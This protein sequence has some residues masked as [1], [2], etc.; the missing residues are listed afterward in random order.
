MTFSPTHWYRIRNTKINLATHCLDVINDS[1]GNITLCT[2]LLKMATI[3][4]YAGQCWQFAPAPTSPVPNSSNDNATVGT[5]ILR[6]WWLGPN[7]RLTISSGH[8]KAPILLHGEGQV[9][10]I[11][12]WDEGT[13]W[14]SSIVDGKEK[15]LDVD[16]DG[17]N[18]IMKEKDEGRLTQRWAV[19][20]I[21]SITEEGY[22]SPR[23]DRS[24]TDPDVFVMS[25]AWTRS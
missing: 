7:R 5:Y 2:G 16:E 18:L 3:G 6:T 15:V 25:D 17:R 4:N 9:W 20:I 12:V 22:H 1:D 13:L 10:S 21:R 23:A 11:G 24:V 8:D 14:F 19:E